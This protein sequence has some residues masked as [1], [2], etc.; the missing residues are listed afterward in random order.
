MDSGHLTHLVGCGAYLFDARGRMLLLL[1]ATPPEVWAPPGGRLHCEEDPIVGLKREVREECGLEIEVLGIAGVWF[2][3]QAEGFP[4]LLALDHVARR[5]G[6]RVRLS[7]EHRDYQ[8]VTRQQIE[9][10]EV[11]TV[12]EKGQGY[13]KSELLK[14]FD[15]YNQW[16]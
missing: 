13:I 5:T 10:G 12:N 1:R 3:R 6:G 2:G 16:K 9:S 7:E 11:V 8:W 4:P 15:L 14:A